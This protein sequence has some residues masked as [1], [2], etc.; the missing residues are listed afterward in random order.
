ML[1]MDIRYI[2]KRGAE[3][4]CLIQICNISDPFAEILKGFTLPSPLG[5]GGPLAVDEAKL[6]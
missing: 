1:K 4:F 2:Y 3:L 6:V 5:E